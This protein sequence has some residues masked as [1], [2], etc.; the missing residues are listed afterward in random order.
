MIKREKYAKKYLNVTI[1][2][3]IGSGFYGCETVPPDNP[4]IME[5]NQWEKRLLS[6]KGEIEL[7]KRLVPRHS[8]S[9]GKREIVAIER[10]EYRV[11]NHSNLNQCL[12][13]NITDNYANLA[14]APHYSTL[15]QL[16][17]PKQTKFFGHYTPVEN[18]QSFSM[19]EK[20]RRGKVL[21]SGN[22]YQCAELFK[23]DDQPC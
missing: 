20:L 4:Y 23:S 11:I 13:L 14:V 5:P 10:F 15:I 9:R 2:G 8:S 3:A 21:Q 16:V 1:L 17:G 6:D 12:A 19:A 7:E 18:K 22:N